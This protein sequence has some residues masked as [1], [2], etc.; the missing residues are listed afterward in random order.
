MNA[1]DPDRPS[2]MG[3][4]GYSPPPPNLAPHAPMPGAP[5][6]PPHVEQPLSPVGDRGRTGFPRALGAASVWAAAN[7]VLVLVVAGPAPSAEALGRVVGGLLGAALLA[8]LG[9]W[10]VLRRR[11]RPFRVVLLVALPF[12]LVVGVVLTV[13]AAS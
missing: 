2:W 8:A 6:Y 7:L 9:A 12:Y 3:A 13:A 1:P 4:P 10:L 5:P 11:A